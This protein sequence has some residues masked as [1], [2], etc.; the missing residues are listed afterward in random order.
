MFQRFESVLDDFQQGP[1]GQVP[2]QFAA[3][4]FEA[5][6]APQGAQLLVF[7]VVAHCISQGTKFKKIIFKF[8]HFLTISHS[9]NLEMLP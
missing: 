1:V 7:G 8:H 9:L 2:V 4:N 6:F 5:T 3:S